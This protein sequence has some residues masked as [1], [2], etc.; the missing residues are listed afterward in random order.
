MKTIEIDN[1]KIGPGQPTFIIAE[2]GVNHNGNV[3]TAFKLVDAALE[4]GA[5]AVKF[6]TFKAEK[7]ISP[8]AAKGEYQEET[9]GQNGSQLEMVRKLQLSYDEFQKISD[10]CKSKGILFLATPFDYESADFLRDLGCPLFKI[11]SPDLIYFDFLA[12]IAKYGRPLLI[13]TGMGNMGDIEKALETVED[14]G[15]PA[16]AFLHCLSNYPADPANVNLRAMETIQRAFDVVVGYSD[17]TLGVE[18]SL[19]AV[20]RGAS[21]IEKHFTLDNDMEGPDHRASLEPKDFRV[22]VDSIRNIESALGVAR[23][24]P[25]PSEKNTADIAR[26]SLVAARDIPANTALTAEMIDVLRPGWGLSPDSSR[27]VLGRKTLNEIKAGEV[28]KLE[29]FL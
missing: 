19:A 28:F 2:A 20:A 23:K 13:S 17:H 27:F 7:V 9:T 18:I 14:N 3:D 6:Q 29:M 26:R 24:R 15:N 16:T 8:V 11:A 5:D 1:F 10:Y 21:I 12:H 4:A 22:M 25:I